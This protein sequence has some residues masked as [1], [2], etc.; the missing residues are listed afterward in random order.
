MLDAEAQE[1]G[2]GQLV[3]VSPWLNEGHDPA[4][5]LVLVGLLEVQLQLPL[6]QHPLLVQQRLEGLPSG[7]AVLHQRAARPARLAAGLA[8][9]LMLL[10]KDLQVSQRLGGQQPGTYRV[11][12]EE[13]VVSPEG[14]EISVPEVRSPLRPREVHQD[15]GVGNRL[16][17]QALFHARGEPAH[18]LDPLDLA[19]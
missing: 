4:N 1:V 5:Q 14:E 18:H 3:V 12:V 16:H 8:G 9:A 19:V 13:D 2:G 7:W 17:H 6:L 10:A 11:L 15:A